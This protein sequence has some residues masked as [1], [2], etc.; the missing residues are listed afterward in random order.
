MALGSESQQRKRKAPA[1]PPTPSSTT[2]GFDDTSTSPSPSPDTHAT[3]L[4]TPAVRSK[5]A[6]A[7]PASATIVVMQTIKPSP[8]KAAEQPATPTAISPTP[9][10]ST[11]DS[12]ALQDSSS[13]FSHS[14]DD[15]DADQDQ[16][17][18]YCSTLTTSTVSGSVKVQP[19]MKSSSSR[20]EE[21][22]MSSSTAANLRDQEVTSTNSS[23]SE[24]ESA[25]NLK[26]DEVENNRHSGM[27][28]TDQ[29]APPKPRRSPAR[30]SARLCLPPTSPTPPPHTPPTEL[31]ESDSP[32]MEEAAPQCR[33]QMD[34]CTAVGRC[35]YAPNT[36]EVSLWLDPSFLRQSFTWLHSMQSSA[37][38]GQKPETETPEEETLSLGSSG[39]SS[40][41]DQGYAASEGMADGD[42]SGMISSPSDTQPT[43][44]EGS[45]SLDGSRRGGGKKLLGPVRDNSSDSDEG[46]ATWGSRHRHNDISSKAKSDRFKDSYE[47]DPE[48]TAQL[49]QTLTDF[50]A[51]LAAHIDIVSVK[52]TPYTMSTDSNMVPV[53]VV[54]IDVPV[55][56]IDEVLED[57]ELNIAENEAKSLTRTESAGSKDPDFCYQSSTK[58][59]NK[60]NNACTAADSNKRRSANTKQTSQSEQ[61]KES[62]TNKSIGDENI[63]ET[64]IKEMSV[65]HTMSGKEDK[66]RT[67][68]GVKSNVDMQKQGKSTEIKSD[69]VKNNTESLQEKKPVPPGTTQRSV[70]TEKAEEVRRVPQINSSSSTSPSKITRITS[71]FGMKT[72]TV[73]PSKPVVHAATGDPAVRLTPGAIKIDDQGNM[74]KDAISQN[75]VGGS[76][77]LETNCSEESPL[78]GRAKLFWSS[79][80]RQES[81]VHQS[82]GQLCKTKENM[83]ATRNTPSPVS[84]TTLKTSNAEYLRTKQSTQFKAVERAQPKEIVKEGA[85]EPVKDIHVAKEEQ[86]VVESKISVSKNTQQP[87]NKPALSPPLLPDLNKDLSF[88][89]PS[90]RTSSQ[91]VASAITK[92]VPKS[93]DKPNFIPNVSDSSAFVKTHTIGF[94]RSGR[95]VQVNPH[96]SLPSSF[97]DNKKND[98]ASKP[99]PLVSKRLMNCP[100]YVSDSQ[101]DS[102]EARPDSVGS[103]KGSS[104]TLQTQTA[105]NNHIQSNGPAQINVTAS[106][107]RDDI[108]QTWPRSSNPA[109]SCP[110]HSSAKP[111]TAP[112]PISQGQTSNTREAATT[113][114]PDATSH[115]D[116]APQPVTVFGPVKKFKPV[117]CRSVEKET[118]LHS[119]LMEAIQTGGGRDRLKKISTSGPSN[120]KKVSYLEEENE[121]SALLAAIRAQN[122]SSRL[123]KTKSEAAEELE[124][125]KKV[126][127]EEEKSASPPSSTSPPPVT[128]TSPPVFTPPPPA[129][130]AAPPPP[131]PVLPQGKPSTV[132]HPS[133]NTPLDP[134]LA[135]VAMLEAIRSGS[136]ADKLKKV[137]VPTKTIQVNGRLG[138]IQAAS[139]SSLSNK[140]EAHI[141]TTTND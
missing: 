23:R 61:L 42:D 71:R 73:V 135:R 102:G 28:A 137:A 77:E 111:P 20:L 105:K 70:S 75:K 114:T 100:E 97:S 99:S 80:E 34:C 72:F 43:S 64:K 57:Y 116:N 121:R 33:F 44:P 134:A 89:K 115:C 30:E 11:T 119:S 123:R 125:F 58:P 50:E 120:L 122:N 55:T 118:S 67:T 86:V 29:A 40:L 53:S 90:R 24:T 94:Q 7:V 36:P 87:S 54:D 92:H 32:E 63:T 16:V 48:L 66:Q 31:S 104:Y 49:H 96:S 81:P 113:L 79:N 6:Q 46:C 127:S 35:D 10:S 112:K 21:S 13:E 60:N 95:S 107:D 45:V 93:S 17:G 56:A 76:S 141:T 39:S 19:A 5:V 130:M 26:L 139:Q 133:A 98:S 25:L 117:I 110:P 27:G 82:K 51:N 12:L 109:Q 106:I 103:T 83:D 132:A 18:S 37:A 38:S 3:E 15:S 88:L 22:E 4:P 52:G 2:P 140:R 124:K 126:A 62:L 9:S 74:V 69:P 65:T 14:L 85:K 138:T 108:K 1:P 129:P 78:H 101:R 84:E 59:Q 128:S 41:P 91:Y 136:A 8:V 68:S 47:D 131:P